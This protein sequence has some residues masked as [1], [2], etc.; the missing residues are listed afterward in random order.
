M[1]CSRPQLER[2]VANPS[3]VRD[4][5]ALAVD[6]LLDEC[7]QIKTGQEVL[8]L[9]YNDGLRGGDNLV[10]EDTIAWIEAGVRSRGANASVLWVDERATAHE[11]RF[12]PVV[13]SA[14]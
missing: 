10:D 5:A 8:V 1:V 2:T 13:K 3:S 7:A 14:M 9:A 12:P 6:D 11:W 4:L